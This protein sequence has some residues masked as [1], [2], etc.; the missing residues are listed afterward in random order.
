MAKIDNILNKLDTVAVNNIISV[1]VPS[2]NSTEKFKPLSVKQ[3]KDLIKSGL[4][5]VTAGILIGNHIADIIFDN[6]CGEDNKDLLVTDKVPVIM[7]LRI[8]SIGKFANLNDNTDKQKDISS[9]LDKK[10]DFSSLSIT[11]EINY[12]DILKIIVEVPTLKRDQQVNNVLLKEI[13]NQSDAS[14]AIGDIFVYEIVKFI[15]S[16][17]LSDKSTINFI[18]LDIKDCVQIVEKLVATINN[19]ILEYIKGFRKIEND[20]LTI[21]GKSILIDSRFFINE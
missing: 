4:N 9:I 7:A 5:G 10:L 16:I 11:K 13:Q 21:E 12:Q 15:K 14:D 8:N 18:D 3:Q 6:Y 19:E 17:E 1:R 2:K 20:Y